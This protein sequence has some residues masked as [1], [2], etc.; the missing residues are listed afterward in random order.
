MVTGRSF[1]RA[2]VSVNK[3]E[4]EKEIPVVTHKSTESNLFKFVILRFWFLCENNCYRTN[5]VGLCSMIARIGGIIAPYIVLLVIK[6]ISIILQCLW[7][8]LG[9]SL[10]VWENGHSRQPKSIKNL[11][12]QITIF[13]EEA[14]SALAGFHVGP[15][16]WLNWNLEILVI[17]EG[18]KSE[19]REKTLGARR[20]PT[21]NSTTYDTRPESNPGH[22]G[23]RRA[24]SPLRHTCSPIQVLLAH[25]VSCNPENGSNLARGAG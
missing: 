21:T 15:F 10:Q 8:I 4:R 17:M 11:L 20:K 12:K 24:L 6:M 16:T 7:F 1:F 13:R 9:K 25:N 2:R 3:E 18:E 14:T 22:I 19:N 5:G 23:E